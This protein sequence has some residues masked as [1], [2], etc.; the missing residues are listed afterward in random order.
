MASIELPIQPLEATVKHR[1]AAA[2]LQATPLTLTFVL[3]FLVPYSAIAQFE[4]TPS[5]R[6]KKHLLPR[7]PADAWDST[8]MT[9][10]IV[11]R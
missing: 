2:W 10:V 9:S 7:D 5:E 4:L 1:R 6:I 3:F 8:Q 11:N